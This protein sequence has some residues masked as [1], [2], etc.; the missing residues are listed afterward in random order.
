MQIDVIK[1]IVKGKRI[2]T[3]KNMRGKRIAIEGGEQKVDIFQ[4]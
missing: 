4:I 3:K 2:V 1:K